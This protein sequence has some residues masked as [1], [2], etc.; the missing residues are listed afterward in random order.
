SG[1]HIA[2]LVGASVGV[3]AL[4]A[5]VFVKEVPL[6]GALQ[7]RSRQPLITAGHPV[8][9][10]V[11]SPSRNNPGFET[12][13]PHRPAMQLRVLLPGSSSLPSPADFLG[14]ERNHN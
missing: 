7:Y 11:P 4:L 8:R 3:I 6:R 2:F 12:P 5:A 13:P 9:S 10:P 1:T 14:Y